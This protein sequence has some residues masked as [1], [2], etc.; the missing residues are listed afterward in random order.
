MNFTGGASSRL[1]ADRD[2]G[3]PRLLVESFLG[4]SR[5]TPA[6]TSTSSDQLTETDIDQDDSRCLDLWR[7]RLELAPKEKS[8]ILFH[9]ANFRDGNITTEEGIA[10]PADRFGQG[11]NIWAI[12]LGAQVYYQGFEIFGEFDQQSGDF[13]DGVTTSTASATVA[14]EEDHS[15]SAYYMGGKYVFK[16]VMGDVTPWVET[17]LW[18]YSGDDKPTDDENEGYINYGSVK[19]TL[20]VEDNMLGM[21]MSNNYGVWRVKGGFN[22]FKAP[23][24]LKGSLSIDG[25]FNTFTVKEDAIV[26]ANSRTAAAQTQDELGDEWDLAFRWAYA[27]NITFSLSFGWFMPGD[28]VAE[29]VGLGGIAATATN[30]SEANDDTVTLIRLDSSFRF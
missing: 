14:N 24:G 21:G 25:S 11:L 30:A 26:A 17:S 12:G 20:I 15:A 6:G 7:L 4:W 9:A 16:G 3:Q 1:A 13:D 23:L 2:A 18:S 28:A 27:E 19:E 29:N 8:S 10:A 5:A 22:G